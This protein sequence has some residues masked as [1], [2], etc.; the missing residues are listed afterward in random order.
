[1]NKLINKFS[2]N[3]YLSNTEPCS[4]FD[5]KEEKKIFTVMNNAKKSNEYESLIK[6]GFRRSHNILYNQVCDKCMLCK[7]I[8][9]NCG[10]LS[11]KKE[12]KK[13]Y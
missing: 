12:S 7:S 13:D 3:F 9:I 6:Y 10:E 8:R 4:Y 11:P 2:H 1:M 5:N